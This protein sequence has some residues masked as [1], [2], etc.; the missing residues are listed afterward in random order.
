MLSSRSRSKVVADKNWGYFVPSLHRLFKYSSTVRSVTP[1][2]L[3]SHN[4]STYFLLYFFS[5]FLQFLH[6]VPLSL[7]HPPDPVL[8]PPFLPCSFQPKSSCVPFPLLP[9]LPTIYPAVPPPLPSDW[10][11][12]GEELGFISGHYAHYPGQLVR[13]GTGRQRHDRQTHR[14]SYSSI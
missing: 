12:S 1:C 4:S 9:F 2:R 6:L 11:P 5:Y 14:I 7:F 3:P 13:L 10:N 8:L